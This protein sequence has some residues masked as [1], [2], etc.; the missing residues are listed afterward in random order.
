MYT[1]WISRGAAVSVRMRP[2][3]SASMTPSLE[4]GT[5]C[6]LVEGI[7]AAENRIEVTP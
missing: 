4:E 6:A 7:G 5:R 1:R 2:M 3:G